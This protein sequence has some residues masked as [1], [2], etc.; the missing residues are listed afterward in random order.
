MPR[1]THPYGVD[2][3]ATPPLPA[4]LTVRDIADAMGAGIETVLAMVHAGELRATN[5]SRTSSRP[6][7]RIHPDDYAEYLSTRSNQQQPAA[8]KKTSRRPTPR[9]EY[10]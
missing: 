5:I 6:R 4:L 3:M 10:V 1:T 2:H 9:R 8:N 7:W